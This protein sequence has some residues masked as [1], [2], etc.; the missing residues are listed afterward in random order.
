VALL[1]TNWPIIR[2]HVRQVAAAVDGAQV[3]AVTRVDCGAFVRARKNPRA[4]QRLVMLPSASR[5]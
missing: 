3:G 1:A 4:P 2:D 5:E